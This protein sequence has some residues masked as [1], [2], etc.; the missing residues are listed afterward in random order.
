MQKIKKSFSG[1]FRSNEAKHEPGRIG[2]I[3]PLLYGLFAISFLVTILWLGAPALAKGFSTFHLLPESEHF[4][5]LY[6]EG[7]ELP[8]DAQKDQTITFSF[9]IGNFEGEAKKY[10]YV[11]YI[12]NQEEKI[13]I[14]EGSINIENNERYRVQVSYT[15]QKDYKNST[16]F[17]ELPDQRQNLHFS[18]TN[19]R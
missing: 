19:N 18:L 12:K 7:D 9:V 11:V 6:M 10:P 17:I 14:D 4:T 5:E 3:I 2:Q 16:L 8:R 15:F 1:I 13:I